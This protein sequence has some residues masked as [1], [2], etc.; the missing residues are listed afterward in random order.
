[1]LNNFIL[2]NK[3]DL[4]LSIYNP[5][6]LF[7]DKYRCNAIE[8]NYPLFYDDDHLSSLGSKKFSEDFIKF[9]NNN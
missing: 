1:M 7:C 3:Q 4:N 8:N 5:E 9:L 2:K 6:Q